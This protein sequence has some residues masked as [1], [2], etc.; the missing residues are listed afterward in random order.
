MMDAHP[1][2][3]PDSQVKMGALPNPDHREGLESSPAPAP[4]PTPAHLSHT[5]DALQHKLNAAKE[6]FEK[7]E[8][9][10]KK[11]ALDPAL[12]PVDSLPPTP[13][14]PRTS[15]G[16]GGGRKGKPSP[17]PPFPPGGP[18][19]V[20]GVLR[21]AREKLAASAASS[22]SAPPKVHPDSKP[23]LLA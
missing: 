17:F 1:S 2:S 10:R 7:L 13:Q 4:A 23:F 22:F 19:F 15:G 18:E 8:E 16:V 6:A 21:G 11:R 14:Q 9:E 20:A 5:L 12:A 3:A